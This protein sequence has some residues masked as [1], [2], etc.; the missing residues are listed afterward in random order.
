MTGGAAIEACS[1]G[2]SAD[3]AGAR[4]CPAH[5]SRSWTG[6]PSFHFAGTCGHAGSTSNV[7]RLRTCGP[8]ASG[9]EPS[10]H[11]TAAAATR[12]IVTLALTLDVTF[13]APLQLLE[14]VWWRILSKTPSVLTTRSEL[15]GRRR[16]PPGDAGGRITVDSGPP[17]RRSPRAAGPSRI[18]CLQ[19]CA[20]RGCL[21]GRRRHGQQPRAGGV[22]AAPR[23]SA[24]RR[25]DSRIS[26]PCRGRATASSAPS[27]TVGA[28]QRRCARGAA[29]AA[30]RMDRGARR[31]RD[32]RARS[33][34]SRTRGVR[35]R[36]RT[37]VGSRAAHIG[38]ANACIMQFEMTRA[39]E[40]PDVAALEAATRHSREACRLAP[41]YGEAW[42]TSDSCSIARA[43]RRTRGGVAPRRH[44]RTR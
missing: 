41:E 2:A 32:A 29:R 17:C 28:R 10:N 5:R 4:R 34:R 35:G 15:R 12:P 33:D 22:G 37:S 23:R 7:G 25:T 30:P 38:L 6:S 16:R 18:D 19:G 1:G 8:C 14:N 13:D 36:A 31:A 40:R 3:G 11:A 44:A 39:D 9:D 43:P 42:A 26:R 27:A 21:A 20:H 24:R